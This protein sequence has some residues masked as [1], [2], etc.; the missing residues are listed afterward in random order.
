MIILGG[1]NLALAKSIIM[2]H[3]WY[4]LLKPFSIHFMGP[5]QKEL[6]ATFQGFQPRQ[7]TS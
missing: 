3:D 6:R 5:A 4:I 2:V 1:D 7:G